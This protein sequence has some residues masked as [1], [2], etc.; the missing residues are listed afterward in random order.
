MQPITISYRQEA[1]KLQQQIVASIKE[2]LKTIGG[3]VSLH[4]FEIASYPD[5]GFYEKIGSITIDHDD[6][7]V[8]FGQD[9]DTQDIYLEDAISHGNITTDELIALLEDL[10]EWV[11]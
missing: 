10:N 2:K 3:I 11:K 7:I 8:F 5:N 6:D 1:E 4:E 9:D